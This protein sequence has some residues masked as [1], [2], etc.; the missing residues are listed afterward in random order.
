MTST[1]QSRIVRRDLGH[2]AGGIAYR[3]YAPRAP[4]AFRAILSLPQPSAFT[5]LARRFEGRC[6]APA[7]GEALAILNPYRLKQNASGRALSVRPVRAGCAS[8]CRTDACKS[9]WLRLLGCATAR[10]IAVDATI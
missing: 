4:L 9:T 10:A 7:A 3:H 8:V 1:F 5:T 2:S 6:R